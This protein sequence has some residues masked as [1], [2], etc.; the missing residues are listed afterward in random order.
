MSFRVAILQNNLLIGDVRRNVENFLAYLEKMS[1]KADLVVTP[2]LFLCGYPPKD[3]LLQSAFLN[4]CK[5]MIK[6]INFFYHNSHKKKIPLPASLVGAPEVVEQKGCQI[7]YNS[8]F[9]F[10]N[11]NLDSE[12]DLGLGLQRSIRKSCLPNYDIFDEKRYFTAASEA[13]LKNNHIIDVPLLADEANEDPLNSKGGALKSIGSGSQRKNKKHNRS[14]KVLVTICEDMWINWLN[15]QSK[16]T[17]H[18]LDGTGHRLKETF[19]KQGERPFDKKQLEE[20]SLAN[21]QFFSGFDK[22]VWYQKNLPQLNAGLDPIALVFNKAKSKKEPPLQ[23]EHLPQLIVNLSASPF[24]KEKI[25]QRYD[26][27]RHAL[28]HCEEEVMLL[29]V[30]QVGANDEIIFDG[31]SFL[32]EGSKKNFAVKKTIDSFVEEAG[33]FSFSLKKH[34]P[35]KKSSPAKSAKS[36]TSSAPANE[37]NFHKL[38]FDNY[39]KTDFL[40]NE[41]LPKSDHLFSAL[42]KKSEELLVVRG[43][44]L[45]ISDYV[46]K[47]NFSSVLLGL[48]GGIDSAVT[49]A[50]AVLALGPERVFTISLP[51]KYSSKHSLEDS[52]QLVK[53]LGCHHRVFSIENLI[54]SFEQQWQQTVDK[55]PTNLVEENV[56]ARMRGLIL[57]AFANQNGHL[58]LTTGN[59]SELSV[60]YCT[61]YGDTNGALGVLGDCFKTEVYAL[62]N[63]INKFFKKKLIPKQIIDKEPSAEL[64]F[65]QKDSDSLPPYDV[66]DKILQLAI[67]CEFGQN[68]VKNCGFDGKTVE[69]VYSLIAKSEY[70]RHQSAPVLKISQRAIGFGRRM[71]ITK[72]S[73]W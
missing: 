58:L 51:S 49:A 32:A 38:V 44:M 42:N 13:D 10:S 26:V 20:Q 21:K 64:S 22:N 68:Q 52:L 31:T 63:T 34:S 66:L 43:L 65:D 57:M 6:K 18:Q 29:C 40:K 28:K 33:I 30:N 5:E 9:F 39:Q 27:A 3:L 24:A 60:G 50:L 36:S 17:E 47:N 56:Q 11:F 69:K 25:E 55:L 14:V 19:S 54:K 12:G 61:L 4:L 8:A 70:K 15:H 16:W 62:A 53:N 23:K 46:K 59:K 72:S 73:F 2:E 71:P 48:S 1:K 7:I 37:N 35:S 45:G 41:T 67:V